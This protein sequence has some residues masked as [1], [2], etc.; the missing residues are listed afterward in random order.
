MTF[1]T[2]RRFPRK[3]RYH[4]FTLVELLTVISIL[5]LLAAA[6]IPALSSI[7]SEHDLTNAANTVW[8]LADLGRSQAISLSTPVEL[9]V[10]TGTPAPD[11]APFR[12]ISLW[13]YD[14]TTTGFTQQISKWEHLPN[15]VQIASDADDDPYNHYGLGSLGAAGIHITNTSNP[16]GLNGN[17]TSVQFNG[18]TVTA[19]YIEFQPSGGVVLPTT[20]GVF[21]TNL[22]VFVLK[23]G[24]VNSTAPP[25]LK[26]WRMVQINSVT[27]QSKVVAP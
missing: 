10:V 23:A 17:T 2:H 12:A 20:L 8:T 14:P 11:T 15:S 6:A 1:A 19:N 18:Q 16:N 9:C 22:Y 3:A 4:S 13:A 7:S 24:N 27:G 25:P 5:I 21:S 26:D